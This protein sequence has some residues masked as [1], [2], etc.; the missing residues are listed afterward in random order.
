MFEITHFRHYSDERKEY[1]M[2]GFLARW[3]ATG[4][5]MYW[6]VLERLYFAVDRKVDFNEQEA[7]LMASDMGISKRR[8]IKIIKSLAA[9]GLI[10]MTGSLINSDRVEREVVEICAMRERRR[11]AASVAGKASAKARQRKTQFVDSQPE[12]VRRTK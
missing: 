11:Q 10:R 12:K 3:G 6:Y 5:G 1:G 2:P 8:V 9:H 4:Y 7:H